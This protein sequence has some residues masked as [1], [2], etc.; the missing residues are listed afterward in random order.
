MLK[1]ILT[2]LVIASGLIVTLAVARTGG[3]SALAMLT[4]PV[5][6]AVELERKAEALYGQPSRYAEAARLHM[7]AAQLRQGSDPLHV[8]NLEMAARLFFYSRHKTEA[9]HAMEAAAER[10]LAAGDVVNAA[11]NFVDASHLAGLS[12]SADGARRLADRARLLMKSP[13]LT[14]K[15]RETVEARLRVAII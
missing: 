2:G 1:R 15:D 3:Q 14:E 12:G 4:D 8:R 13:L 11:N 5:E 6:K 7:R 9:L 10:A